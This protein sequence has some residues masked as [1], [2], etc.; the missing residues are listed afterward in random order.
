MARSE[1]FGGDIQ[2]QFGSV[3]E[4]RPHSKPLQ[5]RHSECNGDVSTVGSRAVSTVSL[6]MDLEVSLGG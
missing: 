3:V 6:L 1:L 5:R 2:G 4:N